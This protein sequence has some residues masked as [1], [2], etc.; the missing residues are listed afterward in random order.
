MEPIEVFADFFSP[1]WGHTDRY[2]FVFSMDRLE[3]SHGPRKCAAIWSETADP[4]WE[5]E[6]LVR[7]MK[8]DSIYPPDGIEG[9]IEFLWRAWRDAQLDREQLQDELTAF[10][11]YINA[12]TN[13]KP[14]SGA[15][16]SSKRTRS[17]SA[18]QSAAVV[19]HDNTTAYE[20]IGW[21]YQYPAAFDPMG[22][23]TGG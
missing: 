14:N 12:S 1:R 16:F 4:T 15:V 22:T 18:N 8:N 7:T 5:G 2:S 3:I 23:C 21:Q 11:N 20:R 19:Y 10:V 13:P 9:L 6:P 17:V